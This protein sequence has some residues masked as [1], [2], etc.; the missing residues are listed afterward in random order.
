MADAAVVDLA[1][2][3]AARHPAPVRRPR[4]TLLQ[5]RIEY[6]RDDGSSPL[7][8]AVTYDGTPLA[9]RPGF[10]IPVAEGLHGFPSCGSARAPVVMT[11][12]A[13]DTLVCLRCWPW[14]HA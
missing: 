8:D 10:A 13:N 3:R 11:P 5:A 1:E 7:D 2:F 9:H 6:A 14:W 12:A 4:P